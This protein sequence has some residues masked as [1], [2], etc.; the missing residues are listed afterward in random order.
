MR[1]EVE[2]DS[3]HSFAQELGLARPL[4]SDKA[5]VMTA[6]KKPKQDNPEQ[7]KRFIDMAREV[8]AAGSLEA[9]EVALKKVI[10]ATPSNS[11]TKVALSTIENRPSELGDKVKRR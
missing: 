9:F 8:G 1:H 11:R 5:R 3:G 10:T 2:T 6:R 4:K 7:S